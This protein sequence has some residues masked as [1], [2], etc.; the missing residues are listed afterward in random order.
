MQSPDVSV[1]M[2]V[3]NGRR[4]VADAL[5]SVLAQT[6]V[7]LEVV[8]VDDGSTDGTRAAAAAV[9]DGRIRIVPGPERGVAEAMNT[10]FA[11][12]RGRYI[13]RCD[14]DDRYVPGRL[15]RQLAFLESAP[16]FG[17]VCGRFETLDA[18]G[19]R[20][21]SPPGPGKKARELTPALRSGSV[22][23]TLAAYLIRR[24]PL[25]AVGGL[26]AYF[27]TSSDIDF[28]LRLAEHMR[29]W[30][31]P[32]VVYGYRLHDDSIT[33][34]H[35]R[36]LQEFYEATAR[37]FQRQRAASGLDDLDHGCPPA[38]P[39]L[40][41]AEATE[42]PS[43]REQVWGMRWGEA[44]R[45]HAEGRRGRA[46]LLAIPAVLER[47]W[48]ADGWRGLAALGVKTPAAPAA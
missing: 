20:I 22:E 17:A 42:R 7:S 41:E 26:R 5:R 32:A 18:A 3:R 25:L 45:E 46:L 31:D 44:W 33:H 37:S 28:Q 29:V 9:G 19:S 10:G 38:P 2:P 8:L 1:V 4:Y 39:E 14:G 23:V 40:G 21:A 16:E 43:A 12:A 11:A 34:R 35:T 36:R 13:A 48:R 27:R 47:P 30:Y 24:E 15:A 6:G